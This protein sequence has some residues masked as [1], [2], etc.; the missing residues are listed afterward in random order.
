MNVELL[1]EYC[2][3]KLNVTES[4]PFGDDTLV[5]KVE[6]KIFM[7]MNLSGDLT[8]NLKCDPEKAVLLREQHPAVK[9]GYHMNKQHWNTVSINGSVSRHLL[10][11][12]IDHS[13]DLIIKSLPAKI[14]AKYNG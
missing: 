8:I 6:G 14:R 7:L 13:Y 4:M 3:G 5:F 11:Q 2:L 9:P 10:L 1:R 12:W